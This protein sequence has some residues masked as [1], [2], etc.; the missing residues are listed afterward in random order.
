MA[1]YFE[2][3]RSLLEQYRDISRGQLEIAVFDPGAVLRRG[4]SV[5]VAAGLRG[6][7]LNH[8]RRNRLLR[9]SRHQLDR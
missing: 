2:R 7:R 3:V 1:R 9:T 8:G 6:I 4:G 5:P